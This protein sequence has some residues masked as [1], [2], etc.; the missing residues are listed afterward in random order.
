MRAHLEPNVGQ[1]AD[2]LQ[3]EGADDDAHHEARH[4]EP[5]HQVEHQAVAKDGDDVGHKASLA[6]AHLMACPTVH[7]A[8]EEDAQPR[9]DN[10]EEIDENQTRQAVGDTHQIEITEHHQD[11][12]DDGGH[13]ERREQER[14]CLRREDEGFIVCHIGF[15]K[16]ESTV[17]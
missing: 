6:A 2:D 9:Q 13:V 11:G 17:L 7:L 10:R 5:L 8:I 12:K 14:H 3:T 16:N 1:G 4:L 15:W